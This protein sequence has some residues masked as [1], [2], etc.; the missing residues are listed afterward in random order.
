M[1]TTIRKRSGRF[2]IQMGYTWSKLAGNVDSANGDNNPFGDNPGRD[3]YLYGYLRDDRRH[4]FR[5]SASWQATD[6]L[7]LGTTYSFS[8]GNPY[9]KTFRNSV[10]GKFED[11]RAE[12]GYNPGTN[13]N[14]PGDDREL[15]LPDI[16]RVNLKVAVNFK[17]LFGQNLEAY[18]DFLNVLNTRA[19]TAVTVEEGPNFGAPR[20][21]TSPMLLRLGARYRF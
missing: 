17:P 20:T 7:T 9:N 2:K 3:V 4:D 19:V 10:T 13:P 18:V 5:G 21:L 6:W 16:Y 8:S 12:V 14:D 1:T 11:L 15:R